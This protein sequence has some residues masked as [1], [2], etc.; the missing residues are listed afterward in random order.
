M[1]VVYL[2]VLCMYNLYMYVIRHS[3][4]LVLQEELKRTVEEFE[5]AM[6]LQQVRQE[7][8]M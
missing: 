4:L 1:D 8:F 6:E 2:I 7:K 5:N 3:L